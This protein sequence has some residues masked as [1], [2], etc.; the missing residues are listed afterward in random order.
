MR[1][2][3]AALLGGVLLWGGCDRTDPAARELL[4]RAVLAARKQTVRGDLEVRFRVGGAL[5]QA[6]YRVEQGPG[7]EGFWR[8][9]VL[10]DARVAA[11]R[12]PLGTRLERRVRREVVGDQGGVS[13]PFLVEITDVETFLQAHEVR[14]APAG[15]GS[16]RP[17]VAGHITRHL[18]ARPRSLGG[19]RYDIY[20]DPANPYVLALEER[21]ARGRL[22]HACRF[23]SCSFLSATLPPP[24]RRVPRIRPRRL[25]AAGAARELGLAP[26][27]AFP[28]APPPG[29]PRRELLRAGAAGTIHMRFTNGTS[30]G[31]VYVYEKRP[32]ARTLQVRP[33]LTPA[34]QRRLVRLVRSGRAFVEGQLAALTYDVDGFHA[35]ELHTARRSL[36]VL[37]H[38]DPAVAERTV[39]SFPLP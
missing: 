5:L 20:V 1:G 18:V 31:A 32:A 37:S 36:L 7:R 17:V 21:D 10:R 34:R 25:T 4:R 35:V 15:G 22:C 6:L 38:A 8:N 23:R 28:A 30:T 19:F 29:F 24:T 3:G 14:F 12:L 26:D 9:L 11:G 39:T 27:L 16:A 13:F 2:V 33:P